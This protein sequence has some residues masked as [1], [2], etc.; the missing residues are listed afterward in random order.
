M[1]IALPPSPTM[2]VVSHN[3]KTILTGHRGTSTNHFWQVDM[4]PTMPAT[5]HSA[6]T[7]LY[8]KELVTFSHVLL[9]SLVSSTAWLHFPLR[10]ASFPHFPFLLHPISQ[11]LRSKLRPKGSIRLRFGINSTPNEAS[12]SPKY[13]KLWATAYKNASIAPYVGLTCDECLGIIQFQSHLHQPATA[14]RSFPM[15]TSNVTSAVQ[16]QGTLYWQIG[17]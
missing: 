15:S 11:R 6:N 9:N 4:T 2:H 17:M 3:D 8:V 14:D 5:S 7:A 1:L 10:N 16:K 12:L 13:N